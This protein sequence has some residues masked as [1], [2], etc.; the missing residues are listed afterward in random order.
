MRHGGISRLAEASEE[1]LCSTEFIQF[2]KYIYRTQY[3][4]LMA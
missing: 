3:G 4:R 2:N 1:E